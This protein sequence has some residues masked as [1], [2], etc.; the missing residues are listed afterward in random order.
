[1]DTVG[2][3]AEHIGVAVLCCAG[4]GS[5]LCQSKGLSAAAEYMACRAT[6]GELLQRIN[7]QKAAGVGPSTRSPATST[8]GAG[9]AAAAA[10]P[11]G[12]VTM[13]RDGRPAGVS[14]AAS[15]KVRT[16]R[17]RCAC[18]N[19]WASGT[20]QLLSLAAVPQHAKVHHATM[21]AHASCVPGMRQLVSMHLWF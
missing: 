5:T 6:V 9:T 19:H 16:R 1:M 4:N 14:A 12:D 13:S 2:D 15:S 11:A 10:L 17:S 3:A 7:S 18:L 20:S 8:G 21:P